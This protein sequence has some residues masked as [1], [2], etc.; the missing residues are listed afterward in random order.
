MPVLKRDSYQSCTTLRDQKLKNS[1]QKLT[2]LQYSITN[3]DTLL[4]FVIYLFVVCLFIIYFDPCSG[5]KKEAGKQKKIKIKQ[6]I[7]CRFHGNIYT[8]LHEIFR[9]HVNFANFAI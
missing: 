1:S 8:L 3:T 5:R 4:H 6:Q 2:I 9:R 7:A